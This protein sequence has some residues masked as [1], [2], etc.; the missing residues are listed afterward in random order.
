MDYPA[1]WVRVGAGNHLDFSQAY[2]TGVGD[3]DFHAIR[4]AYSEFPPGIDERGALGRIA[5]EGLDRDLLFLTDEDARPAGAAHPLANLWD[6]GAD[7]VA[8][9]VSVLA[10]RSAALARFGESN[11]APGR[12]LALLEEALAP[13]YFYHRYQAEAAAKSIG[14][15]VYS[16]AVRGDGQPHARPVPAD[17]QRRALEVLL[18]IL[19][20]DALDLPESVIAVLLPRPAGHGPN[21]EMFGSRTHPAFDPLGAAATAAGQVVEMVLQPERLARMVDFHRRDPAFPD[22]D[23]LA[24]AMV[25]RVFAET[26]GERPRHAEIRRAVQWV[27]AERMLTLVSSPDVSQAVRAHLDAALRDLGD[28]LETDVGTDDVERV[29]RA[30]MKAEI[31]D[32][33]ANREWRVSD[34]WRPMPPPPGSPI[35]AAACSHD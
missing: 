28:R 31:E 12:P 10:V 5:L 16:Y 29:H 3:W 25:A 1:P 35:G 27:V 26:D 34:R 19:D 20:P 15:L 17:T 2:A 33:R 7:P 11:I 9:L 4:Y 23:E 24:R 32:Y 18:S 13:V 14:G 8:E 21:R 22:V 6:N 30:M